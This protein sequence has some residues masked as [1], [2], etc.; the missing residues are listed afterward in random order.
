VPCRRVAGQQCSRREPST[1]LHEGDR[2][3]GKWFV[4]FA[5]PN[6]GVATAP[7]PQPNAV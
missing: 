6:D 3:G 4:C 2:P 7:G 1:A 5:V